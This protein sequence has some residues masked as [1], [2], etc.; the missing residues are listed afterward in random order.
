VEAL[1]DREP[2][3]KARRHPMALLIALRTDQS[4]RGE[5]GRLAWEPVAAIVEA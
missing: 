1:S 3:L 5:K 4:G 2:I